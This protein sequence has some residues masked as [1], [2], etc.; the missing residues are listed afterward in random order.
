MYEISDQY[1]KYV[2]AH[3]DTHAMYDVCEPILQ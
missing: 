3:H 2:Y 1:A